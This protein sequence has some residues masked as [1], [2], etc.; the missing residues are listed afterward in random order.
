MAVLAGAVRDLLLFMD[1]RASGLPGDE[2][3][4]S[5]VMSAFEPAGL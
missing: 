5:A 1:A 2:R 3:D 4:G